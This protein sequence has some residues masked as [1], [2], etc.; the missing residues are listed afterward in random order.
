MYNI[1][2]IAR[3]ARKKLFLLFFSGTSNFFLYN[4]LNPTYLVVLYLDFTMYEV[5]PNFIFKILRAE[6]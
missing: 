1:F 6:M 4:F 3:N 5:C 2:I